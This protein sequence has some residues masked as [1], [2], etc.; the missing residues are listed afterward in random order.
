MDYQLGSLLAIST[1]LVLAHLTGSETK[2]CVINNQ[3][4]DNVD[5]FHSEATTLSPSSVYRDVNEEQKAKH[6]KCSYIITNP[7][8]YKRTFAILLIPTIMLHNAIPH[9]TMVT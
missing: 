9:I 6:C 3:I 1:T 4:T 2:Y 5:I 7:R 8:Y